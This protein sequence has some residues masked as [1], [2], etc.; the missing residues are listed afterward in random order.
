MS[1][2]KKKKSWLFRHEHQPIPSFRLCGVRKRKMFTFF[3]MNFLLFFV[4]LSFYLRRFKPDLVII[5][6][7]FEFKPHLNVLFKTF[8]FIFYADSFVSARIGFSWIS[9]MNESWNKYFQI[10]PGKSIFKEKKKTTTTYINNI[11]RHK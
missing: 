5:A 11:N 4:Y 1:S 6:K 7:S 3:P 10:S 9:I 2:Q 8:A